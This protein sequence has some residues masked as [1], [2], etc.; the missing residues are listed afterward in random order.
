MSAG[1]SDGLESAS[2]SKDG[3]TLLTVAYD[4]SARVWDLVTG[5]C[6]AVLTNGSQVCAILS[7]SLLCFLVSTILREAGY[8]FGMLAFEVLVGGLM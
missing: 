6:S 1:H 2:L 3:R 5:K 7:Y 4:R 8:S